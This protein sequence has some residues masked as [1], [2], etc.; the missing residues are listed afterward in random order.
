MGRTQLYPHLPGPRSQKRA[1]PALS[2]KEAFS[3]NPLKLEKRNISTAET[4]PSVRGRCQALFFA[5][6]SVNKVVSLA[7]RISRHTAERSCNSAGVC[8][9]YGGAGRP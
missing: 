6:Y 2:P 3:S 8:E 7:R 5:R 1:R 4:L 9:S